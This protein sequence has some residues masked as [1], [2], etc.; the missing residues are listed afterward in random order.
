MVGPVHGGRVVVREGQYLMGARY[1]GGML[2]F[3]SCFHGRPDVSR[4][5]LRHCSKLGI[6][7]RLFAAVTIG[8]A[9]NVRLLTDNGVRF[10]EVENHPLGA[11]HNRAMRIAVQD[12]RFT[13]FMIL[14]SDDLVSREWVDAACGYTYATA[15]SCAIVEPSTGMAKVLT[16][17][18]GYVKSFGACRVLSREVVERLEG[19][20]WND[21]NNRGLDGASDARIRSVGFT[22]ETAKVRGPAFADIKGPGSMWGFGTWTGDAVTMDEALWMCSDVVKA[23]VLALR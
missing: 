8:D 18:P 23:E 6:L 5:F 10:V 4:V 11:K 19:K 2:A 22:L 15:P 3:V 14:P 13:H 16:A 21:H 9:D 12:D 17:R 1:L 20:V 7:D